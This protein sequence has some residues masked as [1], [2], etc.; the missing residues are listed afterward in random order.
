LHVWTFDAVER[1]PGSRTATDS[2]KGPLR[3]MVALVEYSV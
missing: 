3:T 1:R 2:G